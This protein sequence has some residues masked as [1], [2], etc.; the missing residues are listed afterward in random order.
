MAGSETKGEI[1]CLAKDLNEVCPDFVPKQGS[2]WSW[3]KP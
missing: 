1:S 2:K 3:K